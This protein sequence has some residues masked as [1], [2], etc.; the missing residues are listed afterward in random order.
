M[1]N[2][3]VN[4][5][6]TQLRRRRKFNVE[7]CLHAKITLINDYFCKSNLKACVVGVSGGID[8]ALVLALIK[9]ASQEKNSPIKKIVATL[10]PIFASNGTTNQH[11][12][13]ERGQEVARK[14]QVPCA[15]IDL[16]SSHQKL[17][18]TVD[19]A[20]R[21]EGNAWAAGQLVSYL[22][23]PV[24]FYITSLLAQGGLPAVVCGTTN[25]D[26]GSYIGY[27]GKAADGMVDLQIISD[28]HKS[29]VFALSKYLGVPESIIT[30]EPTG[31]IYDGRNDEQLIGAPYD[32]IEL[33]TLFLTLLNPEDQ[34]KWKNGL[35]AQAQEQF[36]KWGTRLDTL[37]KECAHKYL[38]GSPSVHLDVYERA[39]PGG[40]EKP[41]AGNPLSSVN[42][43]TFVNEFCFDPMVLKNLQK[44]IVPQLQKEELPIDDVAYL[45]HGLL[46]NK[47]CSTLLEELASQDWVPVG[48]NG[49][50]KDYQPETQRIGSFRSSCYS[51]E[52]A[53]F[54]WHTLISC[55]PVIRVMDNDTAT[56][57]DE[58]Q[59]WRA[60]GVNPLMRFIR[61]A[62]GG[63][64]VPH[65]D[66]PYVYNDERRTLMS[67]LIYLTDNTDNSGGAT[68][69]IADSQRK[70]PLANRNYSDWSRFAT[71]DEV[72]CSVSPQAGSALIFDHRILHDSELLVGDPQKIVLRTDIIFEKCGVV[73][74]KK[75]TSSKPLGFPG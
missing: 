24:L 41:N 7:E 29:E 45:V 22:R 34:Q 57:W 59:V 48:T 67:F 35:N 17:K 4:N 31:D 50:L 15:L 64:L 47:Q 26:E 33:Y 68:R 61:Y 2:K 58:C 54:L 49:Y 38:G 37:N 5:M 39:V 70:L 63:V 30:A 73:G 65:Y 1:M 40:W 60:V 19:E 42:H 9:K 53:L 23:T 32:F 20:V 21:E 52:L 46:T 16:T 56:D 62:D 74:T 71:E 72:I 51:E 11:V 10:M 12:A 8:S 14:F 75:I 55:L 69:F 43:S 25:R 3:E 13:L 27:F 6:L 44:E 66:A 36:D 28:L 18:H